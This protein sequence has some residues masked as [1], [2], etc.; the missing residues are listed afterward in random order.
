MGLQFNNAT[1]L[2]EVQEGTTTTDS[3]QIGDK[4]FENYK[5]S[6]YPV[7]N[8]NQRYDAQPYRP[9]EGLYSNRQQTQ[10]APDFSLQPNNRPYNMRDVS[11]EVGEYSQRPGEGYNEDMYT[12]KEK[13][14]I[15]DYLPF[16]KKSI[17]SGILQMVPKMDPRQVAL[18]GHYKTDD[19]GRV[20]QGE[21]MAGYNPVSGGLLNTITGGKFGESTNYGL[22]GAYDKRM[23]RIEKTLGSKYGLSDAQIQDIYAG[24]LKE[25]EQYNTQLIQRLRDLKKA[26]TDELAM[27]NNV[28]GNNT[29]DT[30]TTTTTNQ[31]HDPNIHGPE[32]YGKGSD[33]QQSYDTGQGF[34][35]H[36]TSGGPVSN[37]TG[38]GR[39]D[40]AQG[41]RIGYNRGRVVNP[42][43]YQGEE[44]EDENIFEFMQDQ[45]VPH[46]QMVEGK[47]PFD[48]RIDELMD[49]GMSWQ[50]AYEIAKKEF[51]Q[52]AEGGDSFSEE[53]IASIV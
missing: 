50:E 1:G 43:G 28:T 8:I 45:G 39:Q 40:W 29:G 10:F 15:M 23:A 20:A 49:T 36:A 37:K 41:G 51:G 32:D 33:G 9:H 4:G 14:N 38:R 13:F 25:E 11:G 48:L 7:H 53:G 44:F 18:R 6:T 35:A 21:L 30:T 5:M 17:A 2:M 34:G 46:S 3:P 52:I 19:I 24:D 31:S 47:S 22:Q 16:G 26:K 27:L 12:E 42:G